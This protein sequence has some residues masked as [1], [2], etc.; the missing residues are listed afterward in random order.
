VVKY[1]Q[2][3]KLQFNSST[4]TLESI[5]VFNTLPLTLFYRGKKF[6]WVGNVSPL[7][8]TK[9]GGS[10]PEINPTYNSLFDTFGPTTAGDFEREG[11]ENGRLVYKL[12][13]PGM[14]LFFPIPQELEGLC[15]EMKKVL[16]VQPLP[17]IETEL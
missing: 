6:W 2:G 9:S 8:H 5:E 10:S 12:S 15:Q 16:P 3:F 4:Q 13:Y 14:S 11:V 1:D 17:S 7:A